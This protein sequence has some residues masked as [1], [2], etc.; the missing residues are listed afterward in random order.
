MDKKIATKIS[1]II[2]IYNGKK[3][4]VRCLRSLIN[5]TLKDMQ[6]ICVNDFS[7]D[8]S[9][10]ILQ[11]CA[12]NDKRIIIKNLK[13]NCGESVARNKGLEMAEGEYVAFI[14]QDDYVDLDFYE[15]LYEQTKNGN[16]DIVKGNVKIKYNG[17]EMISELNSKIIENK[18]YFFTNWWSAI[19]KNSFLQNNNIL[20]KE[21]IILGGDL[22]F[23]VKAVV[24]SNKI[25][26]VDCVFYHYIRRVNS[27]DSKILNY[28]KI[29]SCFKATYYIFN[30]LNKRKIGKDNYII[31]YKI[32][33]LYMLSLFN[34]SKA[35]RNKEFVCERVIKLYKMCKHKYFFEETL[36]DELLYCLNN[37]DTVRL[38]ALLTQIRDFSYPKIKLNLQRKYIYIWGKG[39]D[40]ENVIWQCKN[41]AWNITG[42]LDSSKKAGTISPMRILKRKI[43]NYFIII[44]SRKYCDEITQLCKQ[45][46]LRESE[47]F[48]KPI[49]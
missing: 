24:N 8:D 42:F 48:W 19:Y 28:R 25:I 39:E 33:F 21:D 40:S 23:L 5:Q 20:L 34:K 30:Y 11:E 38:F 6:I 46:G 37:N 15:K 4:L 3:W 12:K 13:K 27:G 35:K 10:A 14:D 9:L 18:F 7:T 49:I 41:N 16:I 47:D 17:I 36:N 43:R 2:P 45:A 26:T 29:N 32:Y 1:V 31:M 22:V 44:S